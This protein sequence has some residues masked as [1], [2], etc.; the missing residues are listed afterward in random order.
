M[1][2]KQFMTWPP[3]IQKPVYD[4]TILM[5]FSV[6]EEAISSVLVQEVD[7][8]HKTPTCREEIPNDWKDNADVGAHNKKNENLFSELPDHCQYWLSNQ[9]SASQTRPG[10]PNIGWLV[11]LSKFGI[12]YE[13][14]GSIRSQNLAHFLVELSL[15]PTTM[16][17]KWIIYVDG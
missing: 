17:P 3:T 11:E 8:E 5:Y 16:D 10:R 7:K 6:S 2:L 9:K 1:Q 15:K 12:I 13:P 4:H 14:R